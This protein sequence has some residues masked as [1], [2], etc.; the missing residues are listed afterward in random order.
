VST[1]W[2]AVSA[3]FGLFM[4]PSSGVVGWDGRAT[5]SCCR[6]TCGICGVVVQIIGLALPQQLA[7]QVGEFGNFGSRMN[8]I[9]GMHQLL[10]NN[11]IAIGIYDLSVPTLCLVLFNLLPQMRGTEP[12]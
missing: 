5:L 6:L 11:K 3:I 9:L 8:N 12:F 2:V 7:P 4:P 1:Y 10:E